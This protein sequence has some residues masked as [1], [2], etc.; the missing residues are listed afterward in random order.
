ML[1]IYMNFV[2]VPEPVLSLPKGPSYPEPNFPPQSTTELNKARNPNLEIRNKSKIQNSKST[3]NSTLKTIPI[4]HHIA[5]F[6]VE[7]YR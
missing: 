3:Q 5:G 1:R 4:P 7:A 2:P 6:P